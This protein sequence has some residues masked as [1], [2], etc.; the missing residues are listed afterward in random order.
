MDKLIKCKNCRFV[1][2]KHYENNGEKPYK[3]TVCGNKF[4]LNNTYTVRDDDFCSR[5]ELKETAD[6]ASTI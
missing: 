1:R 6:D 5:A 2:E 3:K 4:G